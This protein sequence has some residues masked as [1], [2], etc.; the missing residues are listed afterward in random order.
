MLSAAN[1]SIDL[2]TSSSAG[3]ELASAH[4]HRAWALAQIYGI[5]T[6]AGEA[7]IALR[8]TNPVIRV[9]TRSP[10]WRHRRSGSGTPSE[11]ET[12]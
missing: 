8:E 6:A 1:S 10:S 11:R 7:A 3:S 9:G 5:E 4:T 2:L 12:T